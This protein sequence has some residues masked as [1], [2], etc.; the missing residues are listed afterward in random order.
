MFLY[1]SLSFC[2]SVSICLHRPHSCSLITGPSPPPPHR[3]WGVSQVSCNRH[4]VQNS[5]ATHIHH[6]TWKC[7]GFTIFWVLFSQSFVLF[8]SSMFAAAGTLQFAYCWMVN[9][10]SI[11]SFI[12]SFIRLPLLL[13][14]TFPVAWHYWIYP[15][16]THIKGLRTQTPLSCCDYSTMPT[17]HVCLQL[18]FTFSIVGSRQRGP[19]EC[20][21]E[22]VNSAERMLDWTKTTLIKQWC[23]SHLEMPDVSPCLVLQSWSVFM[24]SVGFY[25]EAVPKRICCT[26]EGDVL[27][28]KKIFSPLAFGHS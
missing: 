11:H 2:L 12:R 19:P 27:S 14:G 20:V 4:H 17:K 28:V 5:H 21:S 16:P 23:I 25:L 26:D 1:F 7:I 3:L 6:C 18:T 22:E 10:K 9:Q 13:F 15:C 24:S 8:S